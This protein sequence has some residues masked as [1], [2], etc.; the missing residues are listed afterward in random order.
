MNR[1]A[2]ITGASR[3][4]GAAIAR[5]FAENGYL[6]ECSFFQNIVEDLI[7]F[8]QLEDDEIVEY[9]MSRTLSP[10]M[11]A[12]SPFFSNTVPTPPR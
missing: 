6:F 5:A 7:L 9:A 4:I 8:H 12:V 10:L 11:V 1:T 2:L 3:G